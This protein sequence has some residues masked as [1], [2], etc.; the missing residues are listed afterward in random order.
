MVG[1]RSSSAPLSS[2]I[3][4]SN[5]L[6]SSRKENY[7]FWESRCCICVFLAK[8]G[9]L[10]HKSCTCWIASYCLNVPGRLNLGLG[11][12]LTKGPQ[13]QG[14]C[15]PFSLRA[16]RCL[17]PV[18]SSEQSTPLPTG[19]LEWV[20]GK[21]GREGSQSPGLMPG[22]AWEI[23]WLPLAQ[24]ERIL[25]HPAPEQRNK[26]KDVPS[27]AAFMSLALNA[28][29]SLLSVAWWQSKGWVP[30]VY[31]S[32]VVLHTMTMAKCSLVFDSKCLFYHIR[33]T[34]CLTAILNLQS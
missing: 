23:L 16:P 8:L 25:L 28:W 11:F 24:A 14:S 7:Y 30:L 4:A 12:M 19:P 31:L 22:C 21:E 13:R 18:P 34:G 10:L 6:T 20:D 2:W 15:P 29:Y 9:S 3:R 1:H 33:I 26:E 5:V 27:G 32:W 17:Q